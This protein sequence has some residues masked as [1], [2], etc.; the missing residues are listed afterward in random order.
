MA[1][2]F[3]LYL[4]VISLLITLLYPACMY[5]QAHKASTQNIQT[6][7]Y[8]TAKTDDTPKERIIQLPYTFEHLAP[9]T[10]I[11]LTK[12]VLHPGSFICIK[13]V[14]APFRLY[15]DDALIYESG[16]P[17]S[18]PAFFSGPA[19]SDKDYSSACRHR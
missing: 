2:K 3:I 15:A 12:T 10:P 14:Y 8:W 5:Q 16:Q 7:T 13:S 6:L 9:R 19:Y 4:F 11:T 1:K 18:Y 17:D